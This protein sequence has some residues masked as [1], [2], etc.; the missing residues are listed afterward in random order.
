MRYSLLL[1]LFPVFLAAVARAEDSTPPETVTAIKNATVYLKVGVGVSGSGFLIK[2][3]GDTG[4]LVT[5]AH[6]IEPRIVVLEVPE[7]S[8][9]RPSPPPLPRPPSMGGPRRLPSRPPFHYSYSPA[10]STIS[11][12]VAAKDAKV[13]ARLP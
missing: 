4:Y 7:R 13:T 6:V 5:N 9:P 8:S 1:S 2:S 11:I 12:I 3:D 10:P